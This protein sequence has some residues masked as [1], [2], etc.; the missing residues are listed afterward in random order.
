MFRVWSTRPV[1]GAAKYSSRWRAVFQAKVATRPCSEMPEL[2]EHAAQ[3]VRP[4]GPLAVGGPLPA[5]RRG[6]DDLL[7]G[8]EP[9]RP[10]HEV[11]QH[12]RPVL[13]QSLHEKSPSYEVERSACSSTCPWGLRR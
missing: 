12:Q 2:V 13:H 9:G 5:R 4:L 6:G 11:G 10:F 3:P 1:H 8:E 7:V